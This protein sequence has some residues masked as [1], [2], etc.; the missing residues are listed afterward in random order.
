LAV[1]HNKPISCPEKVVA[2]RLVADGVQDGE[3][4]S[5]D[6]KKP[7]HRRASTTKRT[8]AAE[9]H[10]LSERVGFDLLFYS[11]FLCSQ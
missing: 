1:L 7:P 2:L 8:R 3:D 9:V 10:N 11:A 4:E 6:L 5:A